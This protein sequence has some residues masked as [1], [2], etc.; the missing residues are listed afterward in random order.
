MLSLLDT[1][2]LAAI[3]ALFTVN[4]CKSAE[5]R[6]GAPRPYLSAQWF[7]LHEL[8][9]PPGLCVWEIMRE[10]KR[11]DAGGLRD[12]AGEVRKAQSRGIPLAAA[13]L[14]MEAAAERDPAG[15]LAGVFA[16][17]IPRVLLRHRLTSHR[18]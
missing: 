4:L 7:L 2:I 6:D 11:C 15:T 18:R 10:L 17:M 14:V 12:L 8:T 16:A 3:L 9:R 13:P 1:A 5:A